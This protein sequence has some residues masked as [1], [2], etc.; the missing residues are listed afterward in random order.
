MS[1]RFLAFDGLA[2]NQTLGQSK[3]TGNR[4]PIG[5]KTSSNCIRPAASLFRHNPT[6]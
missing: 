1:H 3:A 6:R 5:P 4:L 2:V